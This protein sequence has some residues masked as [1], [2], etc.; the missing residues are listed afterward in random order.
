MKTINKLTIM[1]VIMSGLVVACSSDD[2]EENGGKG[3]KGKHEYVDLGLPSGTL[4][5]TCNVGAY[6]PEEYGDYFAWGETKGYNAGKTD[7]SWATYQW[8][9]GSYNSL[10]KY[11]FVSGLGTVDNKDKLDL[12]D[13]AA[14]MNWGPD[15]CMPNIEQF[16]ELLYSSSTSTAW[17]TKNGVHGYKITSKIN[18]NSIFLPAA[19]RIYESS[20]DYADTNGYYWTSIVNGSYNAH[21]LRFFSVEVSMSYSGRRSDG[22]S[23]R[24]VRRSE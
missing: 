14:Y 6:S 4:W 12:K 9:N 19:G 13:D 2:E 7:F 17:T 20:L 3:L 11:I 15:W 16:R 5:A 21:F 8:C 23:V 10:T 24:P 1:L 22:R 18:G